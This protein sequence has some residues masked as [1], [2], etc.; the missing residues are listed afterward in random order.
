MLFSRAFQR[1][2]IAFN[3]NREL[4]KSVTALTIYS[5]FD[6]IENR[7]NLRFGCICFNLLSENNAVKSTDAKHGA[8][9]FSRAKLFQ[10]FI[11]I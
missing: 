3:S 10:D 4:I 9:K 7:C 2:L 11:A 1:R 6:E 5:S 8:S